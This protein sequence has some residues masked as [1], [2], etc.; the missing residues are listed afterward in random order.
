VPYV[1]AE[2]HEC[3]GLLV[4][5]WPTI[6]IGDM[7]PE[8]VTRA[9]R[10]DRPAFETLAAAAYPRLQRAALG[11][12][13]DTEAAEDATQQALIA[14][15]RYLPRLRE[16]ERFDG[17]SY[18]LL[19]RACYAEAKQRPHWL[20]ESAIK[21]PSE[22]CGPDDTSVVVQQD[23][24]ARGF[25]CLSVEHRTVIV[26]RHMLDLPQEQVAEA[27]GVPVGTVASRLSRALKALRAAL[28]ADD[29]EVVPV[30]VRGEPAR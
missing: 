15:W 8:L 18:R 25:K 29:R 30:T 14:V 13:Q 16:P 2:D 11:V 3:L 23:Q 21:G 19:V 17:W 10:G 9:Q 22:P 28:E 4:G 27:L 12:L 7:D 26:L 20:P 5:E 24:L 6:W 1:L